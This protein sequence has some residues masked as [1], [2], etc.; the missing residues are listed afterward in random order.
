M[1]WYLYYVPMTL[2]P[3]VYQL[4]G[5]RLAGL[6]QHRMGRRYRTVLWVMAVLLIGFV[7]TNDVQSA[8]LPFR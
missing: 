1:L 4:C 7:L 2:I 3:L 6:E 5:L 8:G